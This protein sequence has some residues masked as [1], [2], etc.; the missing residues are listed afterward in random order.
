MQLF[1][2][3]TGNP[4]SAPFP[5]AGEI[6]VCAA[7]E[8][9]QS[10]F[11]GALSFPERRRSVAARLTPQ[12][13]DCPPPNPKRNCTCGS[14]RLWLHNSAAPTRPVS[15]WPQNMQLQWKY[16]IFLYIIKHILLPLRW[17]QCLFKTVVRENE[18]VAG[19]AVKMF[20]FSFKML[21]VFTLLPHPNIKCQHRHYSTDLAKAFFFFWKK[22]AF[23][24]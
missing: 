21:C 6:K 4:F 9:L 10:S 20:S 17:L 16:E 7:N 8:L 1:H 15:T 22:E 12:I 23:L 19:S 18:K 2:S 5:V 24:Q 14:K 11:G 13:R 3:Q